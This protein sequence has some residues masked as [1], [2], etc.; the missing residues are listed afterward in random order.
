M[1]FLFFFIFSYVYLHCQVKGRKYVRLYG[2]DETPRVYPHSGILS[3]TS[4]VSS[5][6]T[7]SLCSSDPLPECLHWHTV[8]HQYFCLTGT[9]K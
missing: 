4:Q 6:Y 9:I 1:F 3:N 2:E 8:A 5:C 7:H